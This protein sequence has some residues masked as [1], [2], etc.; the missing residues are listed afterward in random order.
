MP[1]QLKGISEEIDSCVGLIQNRANAAYNRVASEHKRWIDPDDL[2]QD[3]LIEA[4]EAASKYDTT[5]GTK[6]STYL[7]KGLQFQ[8]DHVY[9]GPLRCA[10]RSAPSIIELDAPIG[11]D[12]SKRELPSYDKVAV[13]E[14]LAVDAFVLLILEV[15]PPAAILLI[16]GMLCKG[17]TLPGGGAASLKGWSAQGKR[18]DSELRL[19]DE[20]R[21]TALDHNIGFD[22]LF[23]ISAD[24]KISKMA[25]KSVAGFV[26][27]GLDQEVADARLLECVR[28]QGRMFL[29]DIKAKRY[30]VDTM[31][32]RTCL[33]EMSESTKTCFGKPDAFDPESIDCSSR[34]SDRAACQHY[35]QQRTLTM[36]TQIGKAAAKAATALDEIEDLDLTDIDAEDTLDAAEDTTV[37]ADEEEEL[38]PEVAEDDEEEVVP[39]KAAKATTKKVV[40]PKAA[41]PAAKKA[42]SAP[43][44]AAAPAKAKAAKPATVKKEKV[45]ADPAPADVGVYPFKQGSMMRDIF[46]WAYQGIKIATLEKRVLERGNKVKIARD[47]LAGG[48]A[49]CGAINGTA[50]ATHT[51][52]LSE[53]GGVLKI[54]KLRYYPNGKA[55][56]A[57]K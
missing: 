18:P 16:H 15:S 9:H 4:L 6:F 31:T 20:I 3:G 47:V 8:F 40:A 46:K 38:A 43:K 42:T 32:C 30:D 21:K 51:W 44:A 45:D 13:E 37:P 41:A 50:P 29:S 36:K 19:L 39:A 14:H 7:F 34:C 5:R 48:V 52:T 26:S 53:E 25:L 23:T 12:G 11:E 49:G 35:I 33:D 27:I 17:S 55:V 54:T 22:D 1:I 10:K 57:A 28:C 56:S 2:I 24:E